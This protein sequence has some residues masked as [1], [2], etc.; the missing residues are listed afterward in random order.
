M[1]LPTVTENR[2]N[3]QNNESYENTHPAGELP[4]RRPD[5]PSPHHL[6]NP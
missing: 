3:H 4:A 5:L 6:C 2:D 1:L